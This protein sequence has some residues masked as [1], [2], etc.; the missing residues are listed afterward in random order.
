MTLHAHAA[1]AEPSMVFS[2]VV[3]TLSMRTKNSCT[4]NTDTDTD[5][6]EGGNKDAVGEM[7]KKLA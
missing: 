6:D 1:A 4:N 3:P 7:K 2:N 5:T